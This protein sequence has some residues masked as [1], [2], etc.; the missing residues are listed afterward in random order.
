MKISCTPVSVYEELRN[1]EIDQAKYFELISSAGAEA[2][3]I[4]DPAAYGCFWQDFEKEKRL[5]PGLL[6]ANGLDISAYATSNNF[7]VIEPE[8]F[9]AQVERVINAA[10]DAAAFGI[11]TM[12][13]FGGYHKMLGP[14]HHMDFSDGLQQVIRGIEEV[15]PEAEKL[16]VT[17]ALE[18]HGR[19]P[20]LP[21]EILY[22]MKYFD[23][24]NLGLC[25][26]IANFNAFNMNEFVDAVSAYELLKPYI[27]HVHC[28]D[29]KTSETTHCNAAAVCGRGNGTVPLRRLAYLMERDRF[30]GYWAL[31][32]E[33]GGLGGVTESI[34]YMKSLKD[35]AE[36]LYPAN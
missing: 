27:K 17:L 15:L 1:K 30:P 8:R 5:L 11:G 9:T 21:E 10:R 13:I 22:I 36:L 31:E 14:E 25:F 23:H 34:Q 3:D 24:P 4:L 28:K 18:N 32:Y 16:G 29:W 20:G 35:A 19:L 6:K 12:R 26:D 33:A 2:T 7:T